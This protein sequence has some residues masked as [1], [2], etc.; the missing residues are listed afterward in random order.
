MPDRERDRVPDLRSNVSKG[1]LPQ[2]PP[3]HP[4]NTEDPS[5]PPRLSE[6]SERESRDEANSER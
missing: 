5:I 6:E 1:S 2:V 3:A 4:K